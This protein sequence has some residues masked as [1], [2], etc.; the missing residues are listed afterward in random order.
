MLNVKCK[1]T[2]TEQ[3]NK[4]PRP[5]IQHPKAKRPIK[6]QRKKSNSAYARSNIQ[7]AERSNSVSDL[8]YSSNALLF[9][10]KIAL[11]KNSF[12]FSQKA[13]NIGLSTI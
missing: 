9:T 4:D 5:N 7:Q 12:P 2:S 1:S 10:K 8:T 3:L 11:A 13:L 6:R